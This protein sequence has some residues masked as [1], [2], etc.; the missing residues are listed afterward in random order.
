MVVQVIFLNWCNVPGLLE[1]F[2]VFQWVPTFLVSSSTVVFLKHFDSIYGYLGTCRWHV[3]LYSK[4][5]STIAKIFPGFHP[6]LLQVLVQGWILLF[7]NICSELLNNVCTILHFHSCLI[8]NLKNVGKQ[9]YAIIEH[10]P[11]LVI[12]KKQSTCSN[13]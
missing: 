8:N 5:L 3:K 12:T 10:H 11:V 6:D 4:Q 7:G 13:P 1:S 9:H 2:L